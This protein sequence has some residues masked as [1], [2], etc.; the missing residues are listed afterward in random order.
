MKRLIII[1]FVALSI[2]LEFSQAQNITLTFVGKDAQTQNYLS[3]DSVYV[4]NMTLGCDTTLYGEIPSITLITNL[5]I[6]ENIGKET[7]SFTLMQNIPNPFNGITNVDVFLNHKGVLNLFVSDVRGK[8]VAEYKN[9]FD[10]GLH[11]FEISTS[12]DNLLILNVYDGQNKKSIKMVNNG[13]GFVSNSIRYIGPGNQSLDNLLKT[14][15]V[16]FNFRLGDQ[17]LYKACVYG[18]TDEIIIDS[19]TG[20]SSYT[21]EMTLGTPPDFPTVITAIVTN[22]TQNYALCGGNITSDGGSAVTARGI[23]WGTSE[24]PTIAD[25]YTTDGEGTGEYIS[26]LTELAPNTPYYVRAYATSLAGTAYGD[27][28]TFTTLQIL[29]V[30]TVTTDT[31]I[32]IT[33]TTAFTGGNVTS[34]GGLTVIVRGVCWSDSP[35]PT[36]D[37][38]HTTDGSGTGTFISNVTGLTA[39]ATYYVRAYATNSLGTAYG[40]ERTFSTL[41]N[42]VLPQ[43]TT[44]TIIDITQTT[45]V[46]G[47]NVI[48]DGGADVTARGVCWNTSPDPTV[49]DYLTTDGT[50][51]GAFTSH[52]EGLTANTLYFVRAYATNS[53]GTVYGNERTFTTSENFTLPI[54]TTDDIDDITQTTATGGGNVTSDGG[55]P[56]TARGVCWS[57]SLD[58]TIADSHSEDGTGTGTFISSLTGL[59]P[60]TPYYVRAYATNGIG[61]AYGEEKTFTTLQELTIPTVTTDP[62]TDITQTTA[63][64]GGN[65]TSTGGLT[66]IVRG[67]CWST[68]AN[69]TVDN[70]HTTDGSGT[71][72]FISYLTGLT[73]NTPYYVRA[74]ATNSVGTAYGNE[75]TFTTLENPD[76]PTVSTDTVID[77]TDTTATSGGNVTSDGGATVTARGVCWSTSPNPTTADNLTTDGSGTGLFISYLTGLL[78]V[79]TYYIRAYATNSVGTAYGNE[80][81]FETLEYYDLPTVSTDTVI[82]ITQITATSGGNVTSDGGTPVTARGV[83]WSMSQNPTTADNITTDGSGTGTFVSSLTGLTANTQYYVRAYATSIAGTAYGNE[84]TFTTLPIPTIPTVTTDTISDTTQTTATCGGNVTSDG[85]SAVIVR[86][87]CWSTSQNPTTADPHTTDGSGTGTFISSLTGLTP[88]TVYYVRAYAINTIGT[89]YGNEQTFSTLP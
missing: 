81:T 57:T 8:K 39:N 82:D 30:P 38:T 41:E 5:G 54:V 45:A 53:V 26:E 28:Q 64:S 63:T 55:S 21:F 83:C 75:Q 23:C 70:T 68:S 6:D 10:K 33:Q 36:V 15:G 84:R 24:N 40:N 66:V 4:K 48:S 72:A 31:V 19:P 32:N 79:T 56:V 67:V 22:I 17:L 59:L 52:L 47:G 46:S 58:P 44:D 85:G 49:A 2:Q 51:T 34:D 62:V 16:G 13:A 73:A 20:N 25:S 11:K 65:V 12:S 42:P 37:G 7:E 61:T 74:Y 14:L 71:G 80:R 35:N 43:V 18:Y 60:S 50:G 1:V 78:P 9:E 29:T 77:I 89:A 87:V 76:I 69:P 88:N 27:Q 86:G 3:L